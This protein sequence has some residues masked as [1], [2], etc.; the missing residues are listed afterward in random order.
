MKYLI[1]TLVTLSIASYGFSQKTLKNGDKWIPSDFDP[2]TTILLVE[3]WDGL[4]KEKGI[5]HQEN[6]MDEQ[7][8]YKY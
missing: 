7:N 3:E 4:Q 6:Y 2:K 8:P 5:T 1:A